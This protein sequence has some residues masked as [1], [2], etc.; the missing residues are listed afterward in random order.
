MQLK[1]GKYLESVQPDAILL[2][3]E[4]PAVGGIELCQAIR[5]DERYWNIPILILTA[6]RDTQTIQQVFAASADD[7]V[8][9]PVVGPELIARLLNRLERSRRSR[10][11]VV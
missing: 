2:D 6:L 10:A 4:M 3:V 11:Q 5:S 7:Y 8:N 9:K 1:P